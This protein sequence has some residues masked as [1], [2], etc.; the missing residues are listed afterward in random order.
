MSYGV[1]TSKTGQLLVETTSASGGV[2]TDVTLDRFQ[3]VWGA[4][5]VPGRLTLTRLHLNFTPNRAGRGM[6]M[7]NL[8]LREIT[9][10]EL[11]GGRVSKVLGLRTPGHVTRIRCLGAHGLASQIAEI[12]DELK[13]EP[14]RV[15]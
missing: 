8:N 15:R 2:D 12:V 9:A 11:S 4:M 3:S 1:I 7:V 14:R 10:I 13:R 6:A 5:W